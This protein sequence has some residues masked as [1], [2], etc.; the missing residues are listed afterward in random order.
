MNREKGA[1][2]KALPRHH[3]GTH[4]R[5]GITSTVTE[6]GGVDRCAEPVTYW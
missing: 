1:L 3:K 5:V 6:P 2:E 4:S